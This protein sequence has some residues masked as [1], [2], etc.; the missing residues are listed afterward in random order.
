M[1]VFEYKLDGKPA[2]YAA[3]DEA[4]R[5]NQ[6]VRNKCLRLWMDAD[7]DHPVRANDLQVYCSQVAKEFAFAAKLNSQARQASADRAW[8]AIARFYAH[9][10]AKK[11]G[12][13]GYPQF[14]HD[15]RSVEYKV[16]G[17]KL[18]PD[19]KHITFT[20]GL[21][22]GRLRMI[23]TRDVVA[24][25]LNQIKRVRLIRRADGYYVQ[26]CVDAVRN[27]VHIPTGKERGMDV[28]LKEFYTDSEGLT[29]ANPHF[30][31]KMEAK[32]K[33]LQRRVSKKYDPE[34]RKAKQ[35]QSNNYKKAV[36]QLAKTHLKVERQ[37][38]DFARKTASAFIQSSDLI[39]HEDLQ[40]AN[41][42]KNHTLA[43]RISDAAWGRFLRWVNYYAE[44]HGIPVIAVP[45]H[46]TSQNCSGCGNMVQKT[47]STRTHVCPHCGLILDR[48]HNAALN[49]LAVALGLLTQD[50]T[51]GHMATG[52]RK[53]AQRLG[54]DGLQSDA[55]NSTD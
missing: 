36:K 14:Q 2:Q 33:R 42:V 1:L 17:W 13:K 6:F 10:K 45:P 9:C 28:G 18:D 16:T 48:D 21:E 4:I 22:I 29:V 27:V 55:G 44:L 37:R 54:T 35:P 49:I 41:M 32:I 7:N 34:K 46:Y 26:F 31:R 39:A 20:D 43:K 3:I 53:T 38:K 8:T 5:V 12:K 51:V 47:L 30:L 15:N 25:P 40:I 50:R 24:F 11:A 23:G 19:G 52:R